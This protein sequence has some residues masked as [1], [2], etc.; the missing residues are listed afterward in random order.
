MFCLKIS[1]IKTSYHI[2]SIQ[3]TCKANQWTGLYMKWVCTERYFG[4]DYNHSRIMFTSEPALQCFI[5]KGVLKICIKFVGQHP[6]RSAISVKLLCSFIE[7][8]LWHDC[9]PVNLQ[10][11]YR[12]SFLKN[13]SDGHCSKLYH[14]KEFITI[15]VASSNSDE[16]CFK[17]LV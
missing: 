14:F 11:I 4:I 13:I 15:T 5:R 2:E 1:F 9:F 6:C 12:T 7:I 17:P 16:L 8:A 3:M 10:Y